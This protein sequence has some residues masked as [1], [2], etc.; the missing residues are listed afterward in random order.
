M[1][2]LKK[3]DTIYIQDLYLEIDNTIINVFTAANL[4]EM[5][6]PLPNPDAP[7]IDSL[8]NNFDPKFY[9]D[10]LFANE[11][12]SIIDFNLLK[13]SIIP[14]SDKDLM[15]IKKDGS[16]D[17]YTSYLKK[18]IYSFSKPIFNCTNEW[19]IIVVESY[20]P[21]LNIASGQML[22]IYRIEDGKWML[23]YKV[24]ISFS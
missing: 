9:K 8:F 1:L 20:N 2:D 12:D 7:S 17:S 19:A 5:W 3:T 24:T 23:Y 14:V 4:K 11:N 21:Y 22:E 16:K 13:G 15:S 10:K 6:E 18:S